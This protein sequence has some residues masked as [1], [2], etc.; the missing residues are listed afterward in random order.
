MS[1]LDLMVDRLAG[2]GVP[3]HRVWLPPLAQPPCLDELLGGL[4]PTPRGG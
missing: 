2:R 4:T 1:L 3:A